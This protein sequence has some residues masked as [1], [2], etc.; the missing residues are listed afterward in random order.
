MYLRIWDGM[1]TSRSEQTFLLNATCHDP[2]LAKSHVQLP[3]SSE[4]FLNT[5]LMA[6]PDRLPNIRSNN[7]TSLH[8]E[9]NYNGNSIVT[10]TLIEVKELL[11]VPTDGPDSATMVTCQFNLNVDLD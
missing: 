8:A 2:V 7:A 4:D 9:G 6:I 3:V 10:R 1:A 5:W 11:A